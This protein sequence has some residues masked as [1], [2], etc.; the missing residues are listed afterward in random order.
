[1]SFVLARPEGFAAAANSSIS[2]DTKN[3]GD[4]VLTVTELSDGDSDSII[5][6]NL[7]VEKVLATSDSPVLASE[8]LNTGLSAVITK[9]YFGNRYC[10]ICPPRFSAVPDFQT[11]S[12]KTFLL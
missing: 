12:F 2:A 6:D 10:I 1:M 9:R 11:L 4:A 8:F 3:N 5:G 7:S